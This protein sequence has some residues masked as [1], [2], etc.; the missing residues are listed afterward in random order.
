V[1]PLVPRTLTG[2]LGLAL[3]T[4]ALAVV[5]VGGG[6][7]FLVLRDLH[8]EATEAGLVDLAD[9]VL[10]QIRQSV[11][12]GD[13]ASALA[14]T[15]SLLEGRGIA[16]FVA[17]GDGTL[18]PLGAAAVGGRVTP[19]EGIR[20]QTTHGTSP[21]DDG[22]SRSWAAITIRAGGGV[23]GQPRAL[24]F[25]VADHSAA[26]AFGDLLRTSP[27]GILVTLLVGGPLAW[28]LARSVSAPLRRL[29]TA[30][31]TVPTAGA[32]PIPL[33]GPLEVQELTARFNTMT[34]ELTA[35]RDREERLLADLRHDL[36]TPLPIIGG[37]ASAIAD[38]T[39]TGA[40][41]SQAAETIGVEAERLGRLVT[42]LDVLGRIRAGTAGLRLERLDGDELIAATLERFAS[43]ATERGAAIAAVAS[44]GRPA[45]L[46]FVADRLAVERILG[47]L[48]ENALAVVPASGGHVWLEARPDPAV[49]SAT[50]RPGAG[51]VFLV[52][53]D[54]PGFPPGGTD[55]A[56]ERFVRGDPARSGPG[57]GL[58]LAI[59]RGLARAHGGEAV[60]E[61]LGPRG[62]RVSVRL[63]AAPPG[64]PA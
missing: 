62:A 46:P 18:R 44:D 11:T 25:A 28:F 50:G 19:P 40:A 27:I 24:V 56:F 39:A 34:A 12:T 6:G 51:V 30:A 31:L 45:G 58:G 4:V 49:S 55:R 32:G 48:V 47:N 21:F 35:T 61:N 20:G 64:P 16:V 26:E 7:L 3:A 5:L 29:S 59:V 42:E 54:G 8:R 10:P 23:L 15:R 36:R 63:P 57:S 38:G 52:S 17:A 43:R 2:R 9:G 14:E 33:E 41:V 13:L 60:A 53:D 22:L 37:F 1:I